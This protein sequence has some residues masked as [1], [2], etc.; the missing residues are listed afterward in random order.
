MY[1]GVKV[2]LRA[3]ERG[4]LEANHEMMNDYGTL[5]GMLSGIPFPSSMEDEQRWLEQQTS[6]TRGE[7][8]FAVEAR[9][10]ELIGRCGLIRVDWKNRI[11]ELGIM[12]ASRWRGRGYGTDAVAVLAD[13][14]FK[15]MGLHKLK[16]SVFDFNEAALRCY[17]KNGFEREGVLAREL[18]RDGAWHGVVLMA[19]FKNG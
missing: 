6:Y 9:T 19:K 10:G 7:Y 8:Q 2:K 17:E 5:R 13:F 12:I 15:E 3:F 1:E 4:D 16:V 18:Y 14:C 11:G